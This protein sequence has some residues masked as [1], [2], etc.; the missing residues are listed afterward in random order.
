[1]GQ[2]ILKTPLIAYRRGFG[3]P[4]YGDYWMGLE[5]IHKKTSKG[6]WQV[7]F[8]FQYKAPKGSNVVIYDDFK[9]KADWTQY[10]LQVGK[11]TYMLLETLVNLKMA[12]NRLI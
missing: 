3:R 11:G 7:Y 12:I 2:E 10:E 5:N 6:K 4:N 9:V 1:M 8:Q